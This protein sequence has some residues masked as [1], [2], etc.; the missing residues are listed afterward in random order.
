MIAGGA[1]AAGAL[2]VYAYFAGEH[3]LFD[4]ARARQVRRADLSDLD[5]RQAAATSRSDLIVTLTTL[6][7][8]IGRIAP[9]I[10]SLLSQDLAP[11]GIHVHV[12]QRSRRERAGYQIP[13][14]LS[15]L[16]SVRIV[17]CDQDY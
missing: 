10:K 13:D 6:P 14:W 9:T 1:A 7:S 11:R 8:R 15:A 16:E 4:L 17:R 12:P 5:R 3:P 2:Q